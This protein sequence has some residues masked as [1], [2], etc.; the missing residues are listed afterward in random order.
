[1]MDPCAGHDCD[2]CPRCD[3]GRCCRS[4]NANYQLPAE[5]SWQPVYGEVGKRNTDGV[6]MEC[7]ACGRWYPWVGKH[8]AE[9]HDI[10]AREYRAMFGLNGVG[11]SGEALLAKRQRIAHDLYDAGIIGQNAMPQQTPEQV[12]AR[13]PV[14]AEGRT[15][16][17]QALRAVG[18]TPAK[19]EAAIANLAAAHAAYMAKTPEERSKMGRVAS[20]SRPPD[21]RQAQ[22][23]AA[24]AHVSPEAR[25]RAGRL[26]GLAWAAKMT[27]EIRAAMIA[28]REERRAARKAQQS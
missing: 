12:A 26:G 21:V 8:A 19:R 23:R 17:L 7:H 16:R 25:S 13:M 2:H 15:R 9:A 11:L 27:P 14:G 6:K 18:S 10:T 5:G 4:D 24:A 28:V 22:A 1:M 20:L 3:K